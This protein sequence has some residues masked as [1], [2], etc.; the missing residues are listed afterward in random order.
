MSEDKVSDFKVEIA[1]PEYPLALSEAED[2]LQDA[3]RQFFGSIIQARNG[4]K[5]ESTPLP[6]N[7]A[8]KAA[9]GLGKTSAVISEL[10]VG[11]VKH[12]KAVHVEYY[13]PSHNLS[14]QVV[15]D[16]N[17]EY[18]T[19]AERISEGD[20]PSINVS[21]LKGRSQSDNNGSPL[22][23]K[24][25]QVNEL[26]TL[27]YP[28]S[29][30]LCKS[31][32]GTCEYYSTCGYQKQFVAQNV[33]T[34]GITLPAVTI[35]TRNQLFLE[36]HSFL[37]RPDF[38]VIDESFYQTGLEEIKIGKEILTLMT[39]DGEPSN[40]LK[41]LRLFIL[42]KQ[43]LLKSF[44]DLNITKEDILEEA[45]LYGFKGL[46]S[47]TPNQAVEEQNTHLKDAPKYLKF[48]FVLTALAEELETSE[49]EDSYFLSV[50]KDNKGNI[51]L[52][53][54]KRKEMNIP[55]GVPILFIDADL[56]EEVIKVFRPNTKVINIPVERKAIVHQFNQTLS[57]YSRH[58]DP[59]VSE[60][61]DSFLNL[62]KDDER[63]LIVTTKKLRKELT[64]EDD[65]QAKANGLY[66]NASINHYGNLRGLND[67]SQFKT[68][69]VLD[70]NQP[71]N[72]SLEQSA[73]ALW[74]D[75]A[76]ITNLT[77]TNYPRHQQGLRMKGRSEQN[78]KVS[79]HPDKHVQILLE[80]NREAEITQAI[81]RLRLLRGNNDR[82]VFI[83][84][85]I[86][87]DVTIDY[88]WDW[89][90]FHRLLELLDKS[91]VLP[92]HPEHFLR[93]YPHETVKTK[94][95]AKDLLKNL[96]K[97]LPLINILISNYLLFKYKHGESR[98]SALVLVASSVNNHKEAIER[99]I[100][101]EVTSVEPLK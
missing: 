88:Y 41:A 92:L 71:N 18:K 62:F 80:I 52:T 26:S 82:Q 54:M 99:L 98:K 12:Q 64:G 13:V 57:G 47:I 74:F 8:I 49:R 51:V 14:S 84:T 39:S 36:R 27:G 24:S 59:K 53:F 75:K 70:R 69:V 7:I 42:D 38:V 4:V 25:E 44:R 94:S 73:K 61:I 56:N 58:S 55:E 101:V 46:G 97:M 89:K 30:R 33:D 20:R 63:A 85:S 83:A 6:E 1:Y 16:L 34:K 72:K 50:D 32:Q 19:H 48:D 22:C 67:F 31:E 40:V 28:V 43:P 68:V 93:V 35:M 87:V 45:K 77:D 10:C 9:A 90:L 15:E 5:P 95:G 96:N 86:P 21:I 37:P 76:T 17:I 81:D 79:Y 66:G 2:L 60:Q 91:V 3:I 100:G 65:E 23:N 29:S 11:Q 78:V